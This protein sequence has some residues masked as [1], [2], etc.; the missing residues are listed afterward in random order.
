MMRR[1][2]NAIS[3]VNRLPTSGR[4]N[5]SVTTPPLSSR[6]KGLDI[7]TPIRGQRAADHSSH[8]AGINRARPAA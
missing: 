2:S 6:S 7:K 8:D 1:R 5:V 3:L 4:F